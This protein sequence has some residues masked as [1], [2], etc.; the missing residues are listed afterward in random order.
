MFLGSKAVQDS[1]GRLKKAPKRH[2][3]SSKT[4][5]TESKNGP[6]VYQLLDNFWG[7][8]LIYF[9]V[10]IWSKRGTKMGPLLEPAPSG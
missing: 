2:L 4:S 3:N 9:G 7:N 10:Q 6:D 1:L 8:F 5:K